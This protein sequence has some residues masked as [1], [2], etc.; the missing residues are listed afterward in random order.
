MTFY[1]A[2]GAICSLEHFFKEIRGFRDQ[3]KLVEGLSI[4][5]AAWI[6]PH[7]QLPAFIVNQDQNRKG[8]GWDP[9]MDI[10]RI[11]SEGCVHARAV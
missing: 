6:S 4:I 10:Q 1:Y 8:Q 7:V 11:C 5:K 2:V 3:R 9:P